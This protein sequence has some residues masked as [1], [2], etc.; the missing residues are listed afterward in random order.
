[1]LRL[2]RLA[3]SDAALTWTELGAAL[4]QVRSSLNLSPEAQSLVASWERDGDYL[5]FGTKLSGTLK[6]VPCPHGAPVFVKGQEVAAL[7]FAQRQQQWLAALQ[8]QLPTQV[9]PV[10]RGPGGAETCPWRNPNYSAPERAALL[11]EALVQ[12]PQ[13]CQVLEDKEPI[14][15]P[16]WDAA[17]EAQ[18]AAAASSAAAPAATA[19]SAGRARWWP[20]LVAALALLAALAAA[21][22]LFGQAWWQERQAAAAR[23]DELSAL[24][25]ELAE[26]QYQLH[27]L[28]RMLGRINQ[29][30]TT[31]ENHQRQRELTDRYR[32]LEERRTNLVAIYQM[33]GKV[34]E[35]LAAAAPTPEPTPEPTAEPSAPTEPAASSAGDK[36]AGALSAASVASG[37]SGTKKL[38]QCTT[39]IKEGTM[40]QLI[41]AT[42]GSGSMLERMPDGSLRIQAAMRAANAVVDAVDHNVPIRLFGMQGCPLARDYGVFSGNQRAGLK[43]AI[44]MTNPILSPRPLQVLTPLV[45]ALRG[46]ANV[47]GQNNDA[48]GILISDGVDTCNATKGTNLCSLAREIHAAKPRLKIHV[49][50]IGDDAPDAS[51]VAQITGGQVYRPENAAQVTRSLKQA[52][53]SLI[54]VC[55]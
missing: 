39:I 49:V 7:N 15:L 9:P 48:V 37:V 11:L 38:P 8:P 14:I 20:W 34:E 36:A 25:Q 51:C 24:Q 53:Q 10:P 30:I 44:A 21:W 52:T 6:D 18:Q 12:H 46:M 17:F 31:A 41:L 3:A 32:E 42:D 23:H 47:A 4:E 19:A 5:N 40:P 22:L 33:L 35:K 28:N 50:L 26:R 45:S 54:K 2:K 43:R 16:F 55:E 1:M 13:Y 27:D 29:N